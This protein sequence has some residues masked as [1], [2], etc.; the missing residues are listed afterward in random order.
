MNGIGSGIMRRELCIFVFFALIG[1][2]PLSA[3]ETLNLKEAIMISLKNNN[4]YRIAI[5]KVQESRYRVRETWG[6]LWPE[7]STDVAYT[8][9]DAEAGLS[10]R[11]EG[12]YDIHFVSGTISVNA[13]VFYN[14][15]QA[16]RKDYII[17]ENEVRRIKADT[18]IKTIKLY[19]GLILSREMIALRSDSLKALEENL[20]VVTIG[21]RK[22]TFSKL[23][24]LRAQVAYSNEKTKLINTENDY[25]TA[26]AT[27]NIHLGRDIHSPI[28]VE[29]SAIR[30]HDKEL[31]TIPFEQDEGKIFVQKMIREALKN[32]PEVLQ[33]KLKREI[34]SHL[35]G[36]AESIYLWPTIFVTGKY[37][38]SKLIPREE[39]GGITTTGDPQ[40]DA[41][42]Q[43]INEGMQESYTP[44]GWN[45]A[46]SITFGA[47]YRW[48]SLFP[49]DPSH[50]KGKQYR[51]KAK[52]TDFQMEDFI[53]GVRL[54]VQQSYLKLKSA[55]ISIKSQQGNIETAE[56]SLRVSI[57]QFRNGII[58][59]TKLLEA[60]VELTTA[61]TLYIQ[62]LHDY[63]LAKAELNRA[64]GEDYFAFR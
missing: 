32:R 45:R 34:E 22:G 36:A 47:T 19:Y 14:S 37:G 5:E 63:Q 13:G 8:R 28:K 26:L 9:Q 43:I 27:L 49:F 51:S 44:S 39:D 18:I 4:S 41:L 31:S 20:K 21:Y 3:E 55:T 25:Y 46:W 50:A 12:Q 15:L 11:I 6:A 58:D 53:R 54:E 2:S 17:A 23:D 10:S 59:N 24:Y 16:S 48:G 42:L 35:A 62:A 30:T 64:I 33:I 1:L 56:E 40:I 57:I 61:K 38:T 7:L 52:Q 60:N 29:E